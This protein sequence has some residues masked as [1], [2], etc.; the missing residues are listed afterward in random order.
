[1]SVLI[2]FAVMMTLGIALV[3]ALCFYAGWWFAGT[4]SVWPPGQSRMFQGLTATFFAAVASLVIC[5][6]FFPETWKPLRKHPIMAALT[7]LF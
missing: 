7:S 3:I 4:T 5:W 6:K 2:V 1:V